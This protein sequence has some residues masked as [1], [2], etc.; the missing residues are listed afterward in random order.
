MSDDVTVPRRR[1]L[2]TMVSFAFRADPVRSAL[3]FGAAT[4]TAVTA[5]CSPVLI[6]GLV[7]AVLSGNRSDAL[8]WAVAIGATTAA[9]YSFGI[10]R[11]DLRFRVEESA[12]MLVDQEL[13]ELSPCHPRRRAPR[14][15]GTARRARP[16]A[17]ATRSAERFGRCADRER[18]HPHPGGGHRA[19]ADGG[20]SD[21]AAA[22]TRRRPVGDRVGPGRATWKAH[23]E[24]IAESARLA[25]HLS[26]L[27][28]TAASGKEL[29]VFGLRDELARRHEAVRL[30]M[31]HRTDQIAL[32]TAFQ[33][34]LA[35]LV[36]GLGYVAAIGFVAWRAATGLSSAGDVV[37]VVT[38][39]AHVNQ[40]VTGFYWM[41][42]WL[43]DTLKTVGRYLGLVD[44]RRAGVDRHGRC[45]AR[46]RAARVTASR[47]Q[48]SSSPTP[49][50]IGPSSAASTSDIP[51]GST[52]AVVG[53]NG[54]GKTTL[55]KLLCRFYEP[56]AGRITVDG[57]DLRRIDRRRVARRACPPGSRTSPG[58][59][60]LPLRPSASATSR[61]RR[62]RAWID[63]ALERAAAA[64]VAPTLPDGL[65]RSVG[66][67]FEGGAELSGGQWQKLA[68]GRA[69]MRDRPLLLVLDEPTAA[70]DADTE[71]AL[72]ERYAGRGPTVAAETGA[73]TVLV[74]H[75]FST[76]RMAD[77]IVVVD[78]GAVTEVG[79]HDELMGR[80]GIYAELYELQARAYR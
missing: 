78:G 36:F 10:L 63:G 55:V 1:A 38:A 62:R 21:P 69:M 13:I 45:R 77:L 52:V 72:F 65:D 80:G 3:A 49:A 37:L 29:R 30:E 17:R 24:A 5:A 4:V 2:V 16:P 15:A 56:T 6:A 25:Q 8:G 28:T 74:S 11:L 7:N 43:F 35:W 34:G 31:E 14:A 64:D 40:Q 50:P 12:A 73:I 58:S 53:E 41:V 18:E 33:S 39:S 70:L 54:A 32:R 66:K 67:R 26:E 23:E 57:V 60:L 22:P 59:S 68:L 51:A 61:P 42:G 44:P 75:R 46:A 48:A 19:R 76:V 79:S 9:A 20:A 47:S 27:A 71:H